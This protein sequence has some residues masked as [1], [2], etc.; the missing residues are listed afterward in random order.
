MFDQHYHSSS[1]RF[2]R[3]AVETSGFGSSSIKWM[4]QRSYQNISSGE[5]QKSMGPIDLDDFG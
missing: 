1:P 3:H 5:G 2:G 4:F